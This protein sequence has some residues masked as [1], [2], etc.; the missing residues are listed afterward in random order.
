M[1]DFSLSNKSLRCLVA[2]CVQSE[3]REI[4]DGAQLAVYS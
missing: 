4:H 1:I 2:L 3:S